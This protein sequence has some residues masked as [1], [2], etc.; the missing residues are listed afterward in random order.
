M[1]LK[2][3][4]RRGSTADVVGDI[5]TSLDEVISRRSKDLD[6]KQLKVLEKCM[7]ALEDLSSELYSSE[8]E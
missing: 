7:F 3:A 8:E 2:E 5:V 6:S 4:K 1:K